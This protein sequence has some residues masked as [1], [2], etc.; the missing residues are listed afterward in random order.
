MPLIRRIGNMGLG[1]LSKAATGYWNMF[2]PT[3]GFRAIRSEVL[4]QLPLE[5]VDRSY[6]FETSML[7]N[8]YLI[9]AVVRECRCRRG[10]QNEVSNLLISR[11]LFD[12]RPN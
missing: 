9:G 7:A 5:R 12:F 2:D 10:Y 11:I 6:Y 3:N 1:F 4:A 8:L